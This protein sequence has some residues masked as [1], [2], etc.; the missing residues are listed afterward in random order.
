MQLASQGITPGSSAGMSMLGENSRFGQSQ[1]IE[2]ASYNHALEAEL[3]KTISSL[4]VVRE[5]R[6]HLAQPKQTAFIRDTNNASASVFLRLSAC[7]VLEPDQAAAIVNLVASSVPNLAS[8]D[9]T[10][11]DQFGRLLSSGDEESV[12]AQ[13]TSELKF[14]RKIEETYKNRI[15]ELLMP[16][17]GAGRVRAQVVADVDFTVTEEMRE[18]FDPARSVVRSEQIS[19]DLRTGDGGLVG[20]VPGALSNQP[21][22]AVAAPPEVATEAGQVQAANPTNTSRSSTR[23]YEVDRTISRVR[24]S[25]ST[26]NK[27]SIAVLIDD[28]PIGEGEEATTLTTAELE[29]YTALVKEAVG[30][31]EARGDT[32]AVVNAA[33]R[34]VM[35]DSAAEEGVPF[36]EKPMLREVLKQVLGAAI[37]LALLFGIV[38]PMLKSLT[39]AHAGMGAQLPG[40]APALAGAGAVGEIGDAAAA[41]PPPKYEDKVS[42]AKNLTGQDPARVAQ[43]VKQWVATDGE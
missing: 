24:P 29:R 9:V 25:I 36:W 16:L 19:E 3:A 6:V 11:V 43:L 2:S 15:E 41:L 39:A 7:R 18:S 17:V 5:A 38:R 1:F 13:A 8:G 28:R 42:A 22:E 21:P 32:V 23:N 10:V 30:F 37:A 27:L 12:D 31:D 14:A 33:F 4:G 34:D 20:G 35:A 40:Q 26:I